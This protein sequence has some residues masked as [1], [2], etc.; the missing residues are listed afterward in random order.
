MSSQP[1]WSKRSVT[2]RIRTSCSIFIY[3]TQTGC[4]HGNCSWAV[5]LLFVFS[6]VKSSERQIYVAQL[7]PSTGERF[8]VWYCRRVYTHLSLT[9]FITDRIPRKL[10]ESNQRPKKHKH[11]HTHTHVQEYHENCTLQS[12]VLSLVKHLRCSRVLN[13]LEKQNRSTSQHTL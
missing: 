5:V 11:T 6:N 9:V 10:I 4:R 2:S 12:R 1:S 13:A 8:T 7:P 3:E